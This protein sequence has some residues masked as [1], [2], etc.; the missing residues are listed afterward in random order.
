MKCI[1]PW[2]KMFSRTGPSVVLKKK[3]L[4][5][6]LRFFHLQQTLEIDYI[7]NIITLILLSWRSV[8]RPSMSCSAV[9]NSSHL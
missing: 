1:Y 6:G 5:L 2:I 8:C 4:I 3:N 9:V 7:L